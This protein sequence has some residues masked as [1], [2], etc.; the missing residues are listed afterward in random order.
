MRRGRRALR[1]GR[2]FLQEQIK[3]IIITIEGSTEHSE[4]DGDI[5]VT[6]TRP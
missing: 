6:V 5:S 2:L 1:I 3:G 4:T